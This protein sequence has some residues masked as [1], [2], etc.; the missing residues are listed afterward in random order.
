M[1]LDLSPPS[2]RYSS[3]SQQARVITESWA[4]D[5]LFC[6]SCPSPLL[7]RSA[8]GTP[9]VDFACPRC[10]SIFQLKSRSS[11]FGAKI[12]DAAYSAMRNAILNDRTPNLF[13][14]HYHP[15]HWQVRN[16]FLIPRFAFPLT[17]IEK[18]NPLGRNARR[19]GWVGCNILLDRIPVDARIPIVVDGATRSPAEVRERFRRLTPLADISVEKRGW[20]LDV[21]NVVR[22]LRKN[23]FA[24]DE[25]YAFERELFRLHPGN[26]HIRDKIRQQLQILR[27]LHLLEFLTPGSYRLT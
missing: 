10:K 5:N 3:P 24:L 27:N 26:R 13:A 20:T 23:E 6:P 8:A 1:Q 14:L 21:L 15:G 11:A 22:S 9:A 19:A 25:V 7:T 12:V 18:R 16:L 2:K 17:V 4:A